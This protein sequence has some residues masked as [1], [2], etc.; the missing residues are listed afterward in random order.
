MKTCDIN[1][2]TDELETIFD[3]LKTW[4]YED[5]W[6]LSKD[7]LQKLEVLKGKIAISI[8]MAREDE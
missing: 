1:L 6:V 5:G 8:L 2:S 4:Q 3:A 7:D